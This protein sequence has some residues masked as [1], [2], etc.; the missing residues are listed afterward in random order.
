MAER[1][2]KDG[3]NRLVKVRRHTGLSAEEEAEIIRYGM[4]ITRDGYYRGHP[5][6]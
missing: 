4:A 1:H 5:L 6:A 2:K 3:C